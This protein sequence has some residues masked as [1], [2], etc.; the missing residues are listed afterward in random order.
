MNKRKTIYYTCSLCHHFD[1]NREECSLKDI[2]T[3]AVNKAFASKCK[4]EGSFIRNLN[5][6]H[7]FANFYNDEDL[8]PASF[9][10]DLSN[11][12]KDKKG[13]PLFVITKAGIER[14]IPAYDG[15]EM[16]SDHLMG[17]KREFTYQGQREMIYELGVDLAMKVC[18]ALKIKLVV[19]PSEEGS[20]GFDEFKLFARVY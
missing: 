13:I 3:F 11:L 4:K 7:S 12:P 15:L 1:G 18:A 6:Q 17:V 16:V 10:E 14:A 2:D 19:L 8:I 20:E 5:V 9:I